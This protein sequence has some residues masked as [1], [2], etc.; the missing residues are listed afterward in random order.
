M[1]VFFPSLC[2]AVHTAKELLMREIV[3]DFIGVVCEYN[4]FHL[5]HLY[6][7]RRSA[8]AAGGLPVVCVMSGDFVQRGEA[9]IYSKF[10][11][12]EAACRCGADAVFEL[13]L[14]WALSSAEGFARGAVGM[15]G[16]LGARYISFGSESGD[17]GTLESLAHELC[18]SETVSA[19]REEL[20]NN[21]AQSFAEARARVM[22]RLCGA[23]AVLLDRP[24]DILAVEYIKAIETLGLS[25]EPVAVLRTGCAHDAAGEGEHRSAS[26]LRAMLR[27]GEDISA[28]IPAPAAEVFAGAVEKGVGM[29][30][31]EI[32]EIAMLSR[33]RALPETAFARLPD[34]SDGLAE[35][36][37]KAAPEAESID[38]LCQ[39]VKTRR[40][41]MSR[42]R[43]A[44]CCA[45][46]GVD[47][48]MS[49]GVPP[50]A[51]LLAA[52]ERGRAMIAEMKK[53]CSLPIVTK[54]ASVRAIGGH[55]EEIFTLTAAS[56][57]LY[58][59]G[60][61][62]SERRRGGEDWRT[63]PKVL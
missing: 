14:P 45:A 34:A 50:Y 40:L 28:Y 54:P 30:A 58:A 61:R 56:H 22:G 62:Q 24:N 8:A 43:R 6:H 36:L 15:L 48:I 18:R 39:S 37:A 21:A 59:L 4:P 3:M 10:L 33:L 5:G 38:A 16:A 46:L 7:L 63:G 32:I 47:R 49:E 13:P 31:P 52:N 17:I 12:A 20:K 25:T 42:I 23:D 11:R 19:I 9:A 41:V 57:D 35:R 27:R 1:Q 60:M 51:R 44:V 26:E 55:S 53:T 2:A 29:P